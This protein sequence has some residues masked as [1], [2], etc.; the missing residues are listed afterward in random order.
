MVMIVGV[1]DVRVI[2]HARGDLHRQRIR[3]IGQRAARFV[4]REGRR[5]TASASSGP[6]VG[7][8][9]VAD[10]RRRHARIDVLL[11]REQV[12]QRRVDLAHR[13]EHA[14]LL[15]VAHA[16]TCGGAAT[17]CATCGRRHD[18]A[19]GVSLKLRIAIRDIDS[20][21]ARRSIV[22]A[23]ESSAT[24]GRGDR[25][26]AQIALRVRERL[27][28]AEVLG[29]RIERVAGQIDRARANPVPAAE[30][31][32]RQRTLDRRERAT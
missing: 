25:L 1:R 18:V 3:Q 2:E 21:S 13:I 7:E 24:I 30:P 4:D 16:D 10:R 27:L 5:S 19:A 15:R 28:A 6:C 23:V 31:Q 14:V 26:V 9:H 11:V 12:E 32:P 29:L 8:R 17:R 20:P 22:P